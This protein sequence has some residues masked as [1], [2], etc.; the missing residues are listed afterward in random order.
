VEKPSADFSFVVSLMAGKCGQHP[1]T[2]DFGAVGLFLNE[3][4]QFYTFKPAPFAG[5][6]LIRFRSESQIIPLSCCLLSAPEAV[7]FLPESVP[8]VINWFNVITQ[9]QGAKPNE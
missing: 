6:T 7:I 2:T 5:R 9:L 1:I 3:K 8:F 4:T